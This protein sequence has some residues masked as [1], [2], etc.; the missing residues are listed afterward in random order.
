MVATVGHRLINSKFPPID[1]FDDVADKSE[2]EAL[3]ALQ[4]LTNPRL[5]NQLGDIK[6]V[7]LDEIPFDITGCSYAVAPFTHV[8]PDGSRFSNGD[9]GMLYLADELDTALHEIY[10]HQ[11]KYW[12]GVHGLNYDRIIFRGLRCEF[13]EIDIADIT[14]LPMSDPIYNRDDYSAS[15]AYGQSQRMSGSLAI[16]YNSVRRK[17]SVCWALY[18]PKHVK[19]I[20]QSSHY[21][22]NW[23]GECISSINKLSAKSGVL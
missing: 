21:E 23:N 22:F 8:N 18:S 10:Y 14:T 15:R 2:F 7:S 17:G 20:I 12:L 9:F 5:Q 13:D 4:A 3:Y 1:L 11:C 6:L 16:K 19:S